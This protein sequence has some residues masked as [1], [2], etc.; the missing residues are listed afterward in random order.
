MPVHEAAARV[1]E[2]YRAW[3]TRSPRNSYPPM[4]IIS[5]IG[6]KWGL[7]ILATLASKPYRF[8]EL[9]RELPN[10]SQRMLTQTLTDLHRDGLINRA[11]FPTKPPSVE[12]SLTL[13]GL[14]LMQPLWELVKWGDVHHE[15]IMKSRKSFNDDVD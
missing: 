8:G 9:L 1:N 11:V 5:I 15:T 4:D 2:S 10:I 12:Y 7:L 3:R 14:S 6:N 13:L